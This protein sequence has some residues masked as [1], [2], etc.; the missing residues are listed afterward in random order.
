M[1]EI[2]HSRMTPHLA[3]V[4]LEPFDTETTEDE[5]ELERSEA[6][7]KGEVPMSIIDHGAWVTSSLGRGP[8]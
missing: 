1:C 2:Q 8:N 5:P 7:P 4:R 6:P 3:Y